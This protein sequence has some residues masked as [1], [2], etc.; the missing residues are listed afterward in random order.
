MIN[1]GRGLLP[2]GLVKAGADHE[3]LG[4]MELGAHHVVVVA[5]QD[6]DALPALPVPD[7]DGLIVRG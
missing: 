2:D 1:Q 4:G 7:P 6:A 5:G 3:V